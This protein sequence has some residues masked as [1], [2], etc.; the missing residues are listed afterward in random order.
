ME[1]TE[2]LKIPT[3]IAIIMDGNGRWAKLRGLP[4]TEGHRRGA[5]S[6]QTVVDSCLKVG[7]KY[8]TVYA[9]ST[10]N[11]KRPQLEVD[12]LMKMLERFLKQK[13]KI[14]MEQKVR[15]RAIG[16]IHEL[17]KSCF[18]QLQRSI[19]ETAQNDALDLVFALN[20]GAREEITDMVK[21]IAEKVV[22]GECKA[23]E[24]D[25]S[26]IASNLYTQGLPD[27]DLLIRT[28]GEFRLSNFLLWQL[29]Y[30]EFHITKTLWPD[31]TTE[32]F[33]EAIRDFSHR[34]RRFGGV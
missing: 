11:W 17:P 13:T 27:P 28:S 1:Q 29:S 9:F 2:S 14:L 12:F 26:M 30:T 34:D 21:R 8:L 10:E 22:S 5:E 31:F 18:D 24:I 4:R 16:R 33:L 25:A 20:Y 23:D 6:L 7:V 19:H 15:L 32:N 3:H